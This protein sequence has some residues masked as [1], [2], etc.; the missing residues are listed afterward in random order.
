MKGDLICFDRIAGR[1]A[2]AWVKDGRLHDL[3][4]DPPEDRPA[5]GAVLRARAD[6]AMKGQGGAFLDSPDGR[7]FLRR[8]SG[9]A[10]GRALLVQPTGFAEPGKAAP[11]TDRI[12]I[13]S[14]YVIATPGAGAV[15]LSKS[16]RDEPR[17]AAL[18]DLAA[19]LHRDGDPGVILR[20]LA[21]STDDAEVLADLEATLDLARRVA[22]EPQDGPP[23][24][25]LPPPGARELAWRDWPVAGGMDEAAGAFARAGIDDEIAAL[26]N[27][28]H[29][30]P[31]GG[32][33]YIEPT[34]ALVAVDIDTGGDTSPAA[35]LKATIAALRELPR[36]LRLRG[37]G[38]QVVIDAAAVPK[39][40]RRQVESVLRAAFRTCPVETSFVGW[41]PLGHIELTRK[42][43]RLPLTELL[44]NSL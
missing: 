32:R 9:I 40:D 44:E 21:E 42:R 27:P 22:A 16:I 33:V 31:G 37:L 15:S 3:L 24:R 35:G 30:L 10:P 38:G 41:T 36:L 4:V 26:S 13:K 11:A 18:R 5:P 8:T 19:R 2:A 12:A 20:S 25:I 43:E 6:R 29:R 39:R 14:R 28:G 17:R 1:A 23:E 34:R 7:L